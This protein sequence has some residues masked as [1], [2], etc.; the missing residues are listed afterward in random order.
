MF[1]TSEKANGRQ[2]ALPLR[3]MPSRPASLNL[4]VQDEERDI[5][6][7]LLSSASIPSSSRTFV[8]FQNGKTPRTTSL[9]PAHASSPNVSTRRT[10]SPDMT[11]PQGLKISGPSLP[12]SLSRSIS[13]PRRVSERST[14]DISEIEHGH[15]PQPGFPKLNV[16]PIGLDSAAVNRVQRW[17]TGIAVVDF[18]IDQGP[19]VCA[20][21]PSMALTTS[22]VSNI[23]FSSFP[24]S[25]QFEEGSQMHSFR[26]R[27]THSTSAII[28]DYPTSQPLFINGFSYFTQCKDPSS[29]R[30]YRQQA[31]VLLTLHSYPALFSLVLSLLGPT[32]S[33]DGGGGAGSTDIGALKHAFSNWENWP[34]HIPGESVVL[35]FLDT[36]INVDV[37]HGVDEQL[38]W[39]NPAAAQGSSRIYIP[40]SAP[41]VHLP[42]M[43]ALNGGTL[44][45]QTPCIP[46]LLNA[47]PLFAASSLLPNLW[48]IWENLVL[49]EPIL[50]CGDSPA[51]VSSVIWW[52]VELGRGLPLSHSHD[53]RPYMTINDTDCSALINAKRPGK[54]GLVLGV[55]NPWLEKQCMHWGCAIS[56]RGS[57]FG[58]QTPV[59][60]SQGHNTPIV[61]SPI[62]TPSSVGSPITFQS[63]LKSTPASS[64]KARFMFGI[65]S[66]S[67]PANGGFGSHGWKSRSYK[68]YISKDRSLL[69]KL[70][71]AWKG[72]NEREQV[73]ATLLLAQHF[74]A[75]TR[76]LLLPLTRY[77]NTLI[78]SPAELAASS[79][80]R[81]S[82]HQTP[83]FT[84]SMASLVTPL[85]SQSPASSRSS[86]GTSIS[87]AAPRLKPFSR[88]AF[89]ASLKDHGC[90]LPFRSAKQRIQFYERWLKCKAFGI[91]LAKQEEIVRSVLQK[92]KEGGYG[93]AP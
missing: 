17:V 44:G 36:E 83:T 56:L 85:E 58:C 60:G 91:W 12:A 92:E 51:L 49:C 71:D 87:A 3:D 80:L 53:I 40:A 46:H 50:V 84:P 39:S 79:R 15:D 25:P 6:D 81:G 16:L 86:L 10:P 33:R 69:K 73:E 5:G 28:P 22:D 37:P 90:P 41:P 76:E 47:I 68:R 8:G 70:E 31:L 20:V 62:G 30:G 7:A 24:D 18:D 88:T 42:S 63:G 38:F 77:L 29:R 43:A 45:S 75:R 57:A 4:D 48:A 55:T 82:P 34:D 67:D 35:T 52:I 14:A 13:L 66:G 23:A 65:G 93:S 27:L 19:V 54:A 72:G 78:P 59:I 11:R 61:D 2:I 9:T 64:S 32:H 1:C 21:Y 89:F 74:N 26:L